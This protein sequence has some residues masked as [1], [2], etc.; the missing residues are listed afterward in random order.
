L[1]ER[2]SAP[3]LQAFQAAELVAANAASDR[4]YT[5]FLRVPAMSAGIYALPAGS[6]DLQQP[7]GQDE[8]YYVLRGRSKFTCNGEV[9]DIFPGSFIYVAA[10]ADHRFFDIEEDLEIIVLFAPEEKA[11]E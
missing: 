1:E 7:H 8:I 3:V 2:L 9:I 4:R 5:E 11:D 6:E 10:H